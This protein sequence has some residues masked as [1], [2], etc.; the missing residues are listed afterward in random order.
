MF[1]SNH[2]NAYDQLED[3]FGAMAALNE[4]V[5]A[6]RNDTGRSEADIRV[7]VRDELKKAGVLEDA[8]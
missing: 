3:V 8:K 2:E 5:A 7:I 6:A 1:E 4:E